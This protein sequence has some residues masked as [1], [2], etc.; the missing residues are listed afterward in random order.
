M[1]IELSRTSKKPSNLLWSYGITTEGRPKN[2]GQF[3]VHG[4]DSATSVGQKRNRDEESTRRWKL[5]A[6]FSMSWLSS[7]GVDNF[8]YSQKGRANSCSAPPPQVV[9][10]VVVVL[11]VVLVGGRRHIEK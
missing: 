2:T 4:K 9:V 8:E 3:S 1:L 6:L 11:V 10:V 7:A 5:E